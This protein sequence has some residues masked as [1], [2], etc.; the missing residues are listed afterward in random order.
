LHASRF[1]TFN[2]VIDL[3]D[4]CAGKQWYQVEDFW[5]GGRSDAETLHCE[6]ECALFEIAI[7]G[8]LFRST[9]K[10]NL[11]HRKGLDLDTRLNFIKYCIGHWFRDNYKGF[12]VQQYGPYKIR[13][14][15]PHPK[16]EQHSIRHILKSRRWNAAWEKARALCGAD[17][18]GAD[19]DSDCRQR[20]WVNAVQI[21]GLEAFEIL[22]PGGADRWKGRLLELRDK[23]ERLDLNRM[24]SDEKDMHGNIFALDCPVLEDEI[25][26]CSSGMWP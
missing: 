22:T 2:P 7:Y 18:E 23:I 26:L 16:R 14:D 12:A 6:P 11:D 25:F 19:F 3:I 15:N 5:H 20:L 4:Q 10:A 13:W 8:S 1:T 17:F 9:L 24:Q 21:Q